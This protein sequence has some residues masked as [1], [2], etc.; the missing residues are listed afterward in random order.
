LED[1]FSNF[2][3]V[4]S[5]LWREKGLAW[6]VFAAAAAQGALVL[7]GLPGWPCLFKSATGVPCPGCGLTRAVAALLRGDPY[8]S[9]RVH[10]YAPLLVLALLLTGLALLLP[11][12]SRLAFVSRVERIERR[13]GVT[14][15][16]LVGLLVYWLA[17]LIFFPEA[18]ARVAGG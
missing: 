4:L 6:A 8:A 9:L 18:L 7:A 16:A 10:A 15:I 11:K 12:G 14:A 5:S 13:T 17:R 1:S 3:P 2:P